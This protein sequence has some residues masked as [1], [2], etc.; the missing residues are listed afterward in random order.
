MRSL[1]IKDIEYVQG[2]QLNL[3]N[4][5]LIFWSKLLLNLA[6]NWALMKETRARTHVYVLFRREGSSSV[7]IW[8]RIN[9]TPSLFKRKT[10]NGS[11]KSMV[12]GSLWGSVE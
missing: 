7:C 10:L 3:I 1:L 12:Q 5:F 2:L 9:T 4:V 6:G 11:R 8:S